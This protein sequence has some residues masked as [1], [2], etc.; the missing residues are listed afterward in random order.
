M[1]PAEEVQQRFFI[2]SKPPANHRGGIVE[3]WKTKENRIVIVLPMW[4]QGGVYDNT[5]MKMLWFDQIDQNWSLTQIEYR[6]EQ[7]IGEMNL[8]SY[9]E[10]FKQ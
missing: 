8:C 7:K 10:N 2:D 6:L 4:Q 3:I 9:L 1:T 5:T